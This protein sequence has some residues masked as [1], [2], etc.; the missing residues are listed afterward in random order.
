MHRLCGYPPFYSYHGLPMSP[1][2]KHK[3]RCGKYAFPPP[4]WLKISNE[5]N[6]RVSG[7][8]GGAA[9]AKER[10]GEV[11]CICLE[12]FQGELSNVAALFAAWR[13]PKDW[14]FVW[15]MSLVSP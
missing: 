10:P 15:C 1:G 9:T 12:R 8:L 6:G 4:E 13:F 3:I 2:M 5:G 11:R 7:T 14:L